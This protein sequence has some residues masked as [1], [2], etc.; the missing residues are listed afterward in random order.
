M[1]STSLTLDSQG[2]LVNDRWI[3]SFGNNALTALTPGTVV[4]INGS[5]TVSPVS[6]TSDVILGVVWNT[7]PPGGQVSVI[8]RGEVYITSDNSVT[9]GDLLVAGATGQVHSIGA[10]TTVVSATAGTTLP[11]VRGQALV[12][13]ATTGQPFLAFLY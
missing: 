6:A 10:T 4:K 2:P 13:Q 9:A 8:C 1:S 5:Q 7:N 11:Y 12:T 3:N